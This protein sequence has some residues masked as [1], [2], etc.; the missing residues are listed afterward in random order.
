VKH[1]IWKNG[2]SGQGIDDVRTFLREYN[3]ETLKLAEQLSH[4]SGP[5]LS[6]PASGPYDFN[7]RTWVRRFQADYN[8]KLRKKALPEN[9]EVDWK[10]RRVMR[11]DE[12]KADDEP[13][14]LPGGFERWAAKSPLIAKELEAAKPGERFTG[15][16]YRVAPADLD[17]LLSVIGLSGD[18]REAHS[19]KRIAPLEEGT[20]IVPEGHPL[21][22]AAADES[23]CAALV[24]SLG[25]PHTKYWRRGPRVQDISNEGLPRGTV[26]ATL[27]S[28]V[29]LSDYSG[30][31][32]VGIVLRKTDQGLFMLDQFRGAGG[33]IGI[34]YKRFGARHVRTP[35]KASKFIDPSYSYRMEVAGRDGKKTYARDYSLDTV[36]YRVNL[37]HDGS[38]YYVLLDDGNVARQDSNAHKLRTSEENRQAATEFVAELFDGIDLAGPKDAGEKLR[39]ALEGV[40]PNP[41]VAPIEPR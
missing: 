35:V 27:G 14:K 24:Q 3:S 2:A 37:T 8:A 21:Y 30:K 36:R 12:A 38:E 18:A 40:K 26:V 20:F 39:K 1:V 41:P 10:T 23:E 32:H 4:R 19:D 11:I 16:A 6:L 13:I 25:V 28:G 22:R 34:R 31:S 15:Q 17:K 29:Y 5:T 33:N 7:L 9:G